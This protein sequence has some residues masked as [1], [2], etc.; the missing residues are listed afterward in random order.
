MLDLK[1]HL[2]MEALKSRSETPPPLLFAATM[3]V[4]CVMRGVRGGWLGEEA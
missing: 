3:V 4:W 1:V 2:V